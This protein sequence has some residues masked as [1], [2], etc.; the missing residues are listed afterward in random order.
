[1]SV[2]SNKKAAAHVKR[3]LAAGFAYV[4]IA[5]ALWSFVP[6]LA[7]VGLRYMD[8]YTLTFVRIAITVAGFAVVLL[9]M[10]KSAKVDKGDIPWLILGGLGMG[11]NYALYIMGIKH[12]TASAANLVVQIEVVSLILLSWM[13]LKERMTG[14]KLLGILLTLA[15]VGVVLLDG[16]APGQI[17]ASSNFTGNILVFLSGPAWGC[18]G[19][20]Q[21]ILTDR[22]ASSLGSLVW[23]FT[24]SAVVTSVPAAVLG[25]HVQPMGFWPVMAVVALALACTVLGYILIARGF[26]AL[27][28]ST[29]ASTTSILPVFTIFNAHFLLGEA[30]TGVILLGAVLV[31]AGIV[32]VARADSYAALE[33]R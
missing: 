11:G 32:T 3:T 17:L 25:G 10:R 31:I 24:V 7:K 26:E 18:Y 6:M 20:A 30:V 29:V 33:K 19:L 1:M 14:V 21:K 9:L 5:N 8:P 13:F 22:K 4:L 15:G 2:V 12:T 23:I 28:A 27:D 16:K